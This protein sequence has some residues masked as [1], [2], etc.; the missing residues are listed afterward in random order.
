[1]AAPLRAEDVPTC[2]M[3]AV[4]LYDFAYYAEWPLKTA[5]PLRVCVLGEAQFGERLDGLQ[6]C[7]L[8]VHPI[9][10]SH[11]AS[12]AELDGCK[13]LYVARSEAGA[14]SLVVQALRGRPVLTVADSP[15]ATREGIM[16]NMAITD[17]SVKFSVNRRAARAAGLD[18]SSKMLHLAIE[19]IQ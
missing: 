11:R 3:K 1:M 6:S 13:V 16:I 8:G 10:V 4:A 15:G 19:V 5:E 17:R 14:M 7:S 12:P 2:R 18:F 9:S